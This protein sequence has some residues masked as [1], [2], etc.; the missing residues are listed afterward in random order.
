MKD[1]CGLLQKSF[2]DSHIKVW[3]KLQLLKFLIAHLREYIPL[4]LYSFRWNIETSYYEQKTFWSFCS[5]MVRSHKGMLTKTSGDLESP[6][7]LK[8]A[9]SRL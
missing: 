2:I 4:F 8:A 3:I 6:I 7:P 1:F 5:Y 9:L